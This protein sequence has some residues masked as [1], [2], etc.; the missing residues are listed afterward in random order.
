M[1]GEREK[2]EKS[3]LSCYEMTRIYC[4]VRCLTS[5]IFSPQIMVFVFRIFLTFLSIYIIFKY[6]KIMMS[7]GFWD[8]SNRLDK[9]TKKCT[10]RTTGSMPAPIFRTLP[11]STPE[12]LHF[13]LFEWPL[14]GSCL[15]IESV[16]ERTHPTGIELHGL[17]E[18][19]RGIIT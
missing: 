6:Q 12:L 15:P 19:V 5:S 8:P 13:L 10:S 7:S 3:N 1:K 18:T 16:Y 11:D 4:K 17:N 9:L 14:H 2:G